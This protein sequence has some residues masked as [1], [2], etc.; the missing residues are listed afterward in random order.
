MARQKRRAP[1]PSLGIP[2]GS[3]SKS[4][5]RPTQRHPPVRSLATLNLW[6]KELIIFPV[7]NHQVGDN[8]AEG[9]KT[10]KFSVLLGGFLAL[11]G[12]NFKGL[13]IVTKG[14]GNCYRYLMPQA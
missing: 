1:S 4:T 11:C 13:V 5:S 10:N 9:H 6:E 7:Q 12:S 8:R 14:S 3:F 2:A